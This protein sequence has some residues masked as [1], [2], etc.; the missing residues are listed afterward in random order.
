MAKACKTFIEEQLNFSASSVKVERFEQDRCANCGR[1]MDLVLTCPL[2]GEHMP[3]LKKRKKHKQQDTAT[4]FCPKCCRYFTPQGYKT[5]AK[6]CKAIRPRTAAEID[7]I[8]DCF[9]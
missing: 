7:G 3:D 4:S 9:G 1:V 2:C 6:T 5:H 8:P